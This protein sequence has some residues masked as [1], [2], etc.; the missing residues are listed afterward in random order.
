MRSD[1]G[2]R[3][4]VSRNS[5]FRRA[6]SALWAFPLL[7]LVPLRLL[8]DIRAA[9]LWLSVA[10]VGLALKWPTETVAIVLFS[11]FFPVASLLSAETGVGANIDGLR[12]VGFAVLIT[13]ASASVWRSRRPDGVAFLWL[14][15]AA[16]YGL[17]LLWTEA[18]TEGARFF[19]RLIVP[20]ALYWL[21]RALPNPD[22][23]ATAWQA[24]AISISVLAFILF[25]SDPGSTRYLVYESFRYTIPFG[26]YFPAAFAFLSATLA[27]SFLVRAIRAHRIGPLIGFALFAAQTV[28][29]QT[30]IAVAALAFTS[31]IV[32]F[33]EQP[34]RKARLA[35]LTAAVFSGVVVLATSESVVA[36]F[37]L[38]RGGG[39][40]SGLGSNV[41]GFIDLRGRLLLWGPVIERYRAAN[42]FLGAG[43]GTAAAAV[44]ALD[45]PVTLSAPHQE[46]L[47]ILTDSGLVG[48]TLL[49]AW[50][51]AILR[52]TMKAIGSRFP[53]QDSKGRASEALAIS[54][55]LLLTA[56]TDNSL[57]YYLLFPAYLAITL[58]AQHDGEPLQPAAVE[59]PAREPA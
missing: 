22:R 17:S 50:A 48:L 45:L 12:L 18:F 44:S 47:R 36:W 46:Y 33:A 53:D 20:A 58:A 29:T 38:R 57:D 27:I 23:L 31:F 55:M 35:W 49:L 3:S 30:R 56:L 19:I 42:P 25:I 11:Q 43:A 15:L 4:A 5:T 9:A 59:A 14:G 39:A 51:I 28:A 52:R 34:T 13:A 37:A 6:V 32:V 24:G 40:L 41:L 8:V 2:G 26:G 7:S 16:F 21:A 54:I 10:A 1:A